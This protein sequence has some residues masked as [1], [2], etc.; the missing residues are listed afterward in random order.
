MSQP[1]SIV[2]LAYPGCTLLDFAGPHAALSSIPGARAGLYWKE[3]GQ[4]RTDS[5]AIVFADH[6]LD[7]V[8]DKPTV[9]L[10]PGGV[11]GTMSLLEDRQVLDWLKKVGDSAEWVTSVCT[12][13]LV[14]AAAGL[15]DGYRATSHWAVRDQLALFGA[16]PTE[17][18]VV[19]DR[20]RLTGGGVTAGIDFG[21]T[22][23]ERLAGHKVACAI[24]L[25][26]EYSPEPPFQTGT[27]EQAGPELTAQL[28]QSFNID[29]MRAVL[30][31]VAAARKAPQLMT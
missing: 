2:I 11:A 22:L 12:G 31:T 4:V 29:G 5:G 1:I 6:S 3:C 13:A 16:I 23:A 28:R 25:G 15:L 21:L 8:P 27:P 18:R 7:E 19:E 24:E 9:L 30:K 14:L 20:N 17:A 26:M 10:V